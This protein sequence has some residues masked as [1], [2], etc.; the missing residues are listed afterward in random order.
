M[1]HQESSHVKCHRCGARFDRKAWA[2]LALVERIPPPEVGRV[3]LDWPSDHAIEVRRCRRCAR[4]VPAV[5][6]IEEGAPAGRK[7]VRA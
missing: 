3:L 5:R 7:V 6:Q 1:T 2:T 4:E